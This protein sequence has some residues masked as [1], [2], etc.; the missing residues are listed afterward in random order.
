MMLPYARRSMAGTTALQARK[1][2]VTF[3]SKIRCHD[4]SVISQ[5]G[6]MELIPAE[7]TIT[8]TRP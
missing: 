1:M 3:T 4:S 6:T 7:L 8:S 2:D 5:A